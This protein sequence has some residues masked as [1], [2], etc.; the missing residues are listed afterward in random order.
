MEGK[1][2][3]LSNLRN[4]EPYGQDPYTIHLPELRHRSFPLAGKCDGCGA[5]NTII[6]EDPTS[7]IGGGPVR[8]PKKGRPVVLTTLDGEIEE[9]PRIE[10]GISA[11]D[12]ATGGGFG[13][14]RRCWSAAIPAS[15]SRLADAAAA[16]LSRKGPSRHLCLGEEA[17]AQVRLR[18]SA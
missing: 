11:F 5:W 7:G 16:A 10:C 14:A 13:A 9:A 15:A 18:A 2:L 3:H 6:E 12:R 17:I 8:A 1:T 4:S